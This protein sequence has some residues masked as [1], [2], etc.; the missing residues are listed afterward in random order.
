M[1]RRSCTTLSIPVPADTEEANAVLWRIG[2]IERSVLEIDQAFAAQVAALRQGQSIDSELALL[3][4]EYEKITKGLKIFAE[5]H[6]E[7]LLPEG[8]GKTVKLPA[9][10]F[11]WRV[12]ASAKVVH[13]RLKEETV[14]ERIKSLGKAFA[15]K[16][17]RV[18]EELNKEALLADRPKVPGVTYSQPE[19][20]FFEANPA[21]DD[22]EAASNVVRRSEKQ[23]A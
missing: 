7:A 19:K 18:R 5:S 14:I 21:V 23:V 4:S 2:E 12:N 3:N 11:G 20:F 13:G 9:G 17:V 16:Y 1:S 10:S 8:S 15:D 22:V 6:R